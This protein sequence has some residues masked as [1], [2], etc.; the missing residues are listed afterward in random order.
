MSDELEVEEISYAL[1]IQQPGRAQ[2]VVTHYLRMLMNFRYGLDLLVAHTVS[3]G[4]AI[5]KNHAGKIA[6][7]FVVQ[8]YEIDS[9]K[10]I[11]ALSQ[12][13]TIP[14]FLVLPG[15]FGKN[16]NQRCQ[17][18]PN[19]SLSSW[20]KAFSGSAMS[21][22]NQ[23]EK[24]FK[25]NRI[26]VLLNGAEDMEY[27]E[28]Q[29]RIKKRVKN[30]K[31][32]PTLPEFVIR[33]MRLMQDPEATVDQMEAVI[34]TDPSIVWKLLDVMRAPAFAG[35]RRS[36]WTLKDVI[37]RL[38]MRKV[39]AIAQQIKFM[40]SFVGI[41]RTSFNIERFWEHSLGSAMIA[42]R[43]YSK[44]MITFGE[45]LE[46]DEY[47]IASLL[48][49]LGKLVLG[50]YFS[51]HHRKVLNRMAFRQGSMQD[52]LRA[53]ADLNCSGL[54]EE[55]IR[56]L[57]IKANLGPRME[58]ALA[59]QAATSDGRVPRVMTTTTVSAGRSTRPDPP[60]GL[61]CLVH[62]ADNLSRDLG[63]GYLEKETGD[64]N[65]TVLRQ[66]GLSRGDVQGIAESLG[67]PMVEE[68][69][70]LVRRSTSVSDEKKT[71]NRRRP[72]GEKR[73]E[74]NTEE[75]PPTQPENTDTAHSAQLRE[76]LDKLTDTVSRERELPEARRA[77]LLV[78]ID[79]IRVQISKST[80]NKQIIS[81]LLDGLADVE[82]CEGLVAQAQEKLTENL[83]LLTNG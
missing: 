49:D 33:L 77:D 26:D 81:I 42:D 52:Y 61:T 47:W 22:R 51:K 7:G 80:P 53:E 6:C 34:S 72:G 17:R 36:D 38:G 3:E 2:Q 83:E 13:G 1:I 29:R 60:G 56:L 25:A 46:F 82:A 57:C 8:D 65:P 71:A 48:H 44:K 67:E 39:G 32:L 12:Q 74:I 24:S 11:G 78:D 79:N 16:S 63:L 64:Y 37:V 27:A 66:L 75:L 54:S 68:I 76:L 21:L 18:M 40:N 41:D 35:S 73:K 69:R 23:V 28:L 59:G 70:E 5:T 45:K 14:L 55:V 31:T 4:W 58:K 50:V 15:R 10:S 43:L 20:E 9:W 19:V 62:M 30:L